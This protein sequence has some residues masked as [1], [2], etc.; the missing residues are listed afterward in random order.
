VKDGKALN[1]KKKKFKCVYMMMA[2]GCVIDYQEE[3]K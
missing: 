2:G 1:I 3:V